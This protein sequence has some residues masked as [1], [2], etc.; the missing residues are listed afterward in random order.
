VRVRRYPEAVPP[1]SDDRPPTHPVPLSPSPE[2]PEEGSPRD[3]GAFAHVSRR[4]YGAHGHQLKNTNLAARTQLLR[5]AVWSGIAIL[6]GA[7]L[8]VFLAREYPGGVLWLLV[9]GVGFPLLVFLGGVALTTASGRAASTLHNP[10]GGSTPFRR[11]HSG[12]EA[13]RVRGEFAAAIEAFERAAQEYPD[14]PGPWIEVAR[15]HRDSL[16]DPEEAARAFKRAL[17]H[18]GLGAGQRFLATREL[19]EIY[20]HRMNEPRRALPLLARLAE[21]QPGTP[22]GE[23]AARELVEVKALVFG[24][25]EV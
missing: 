10:S 8:G 3:E 5:L 7:G 17:G 1:S 24:E 11:Q 12:A 22:P 19:C 18:P 14:D 6:P 13:L 15:I 16:S 20:T 2:F 4:E 23:W 21:T 9:G 25:G